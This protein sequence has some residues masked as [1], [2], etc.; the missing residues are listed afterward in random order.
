[1]IKR[2]IEK[3]YLRSVAPFFRWRMRSQVRPDDVFIVSFPKSG[4][5]WLAFMIAWILNEEF[6]L[7]DNLT[8]KKFREILPDVNRA[9]GFPFIMNKYKNLPSPRFFTIHATPFFRNVFP[10]VIYLV[11][12][13]RDVLVSYYYHHKR[14]EKN[15]K[16]S[17]DEFIN[18]Y[19]N[20]YPCSWNEHVSG[21]LELKGKS[22]FL[23][24][25]YEDLFENSEEILKEIFKMIG[26]QAGNEKIRAAVDAGKFENM[27][28]LELK[29]GEGNT[30]KGD[31]NIKYL[32]KGKAAAY[33]EELNQKQISLVNNK[34][35]SVI[36][37]LSLNY[38]SD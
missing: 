19:D 26:F 37:K 7:I 14:Y 8:L 13:P 20:V 27:R 33:L 5:N 24:Y 38:T 23:F 28:K 2:K 4:T 35:Q 34:V 10:F 32:R 6:K 9:L 12:D 31:R 36:S 15:F 3:A 22:N 11:R 30:V 25:R 17:M 1:M 18:Q 21:W 29:F 16:L